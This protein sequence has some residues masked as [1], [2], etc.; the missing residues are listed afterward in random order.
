MTVIMMK[1]IK[2]ILFTGV[3][4]L[5]FAGSARA[6]GYEFLGQHGDWDAFADKKSKASVCYIGSNAI[7]DEGDYKKRGDIY[8][9]VTKRKSEKYRDVVSFNFGYTL[10][11]KQDVTVQIGSKKFKL[12]TSG[13]TAWTYDAKDDAALVKM[14]QAGSEMIVNGVSSRG[15]KTK[16][17]YSLKG[18]SAAYREISKIC[19]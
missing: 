8:V 17:T 11:P 14:M 15:T 13:E 10:K 7:K 12:F 18:I 6:Q 5:A 3:L 9:L 16:D 1:M 4:A 19:R 2:S